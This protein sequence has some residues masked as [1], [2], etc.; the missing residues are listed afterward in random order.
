MVSAEIGQ[1]PRAEAEE[2][3]FVLRT[4]DF[5]FHRKRIK[6]ELARSVFASGNLDAGTAML[7]RHLQSIPLD[8]V[9]RIL[10]L[11]CGNG[12]LGVVLRALDP[13]RHL[14][15]VD[16][17]ALACRYTRRNLAGNG[18]GSGSGLSDDRILGSLGY[19]DI[20]EDRFDLI[21]S[22][23]PGKAG[24]E[25]IANLIG[26]AASVADDGAIVGLVVV[27]P[28]AHLVS[29][30]VEE[31]G[32]EVL[33]AKGNNTHH[34]ILA[35]VT[36]PSPSSLQP[37][38]A[39]ATGTYDRKKAEFSDRSMRWTVRTVTGLPEFDSLSYPS[40]MLRNALQGVEAGP[41]V[42]VNAG[43]GHRAVIAGRSG[44]PPATLI[45][46]DLLSL[47][48]AS[49]SLVDN[50]FASPNLVHDITV[51]AGLGQGSTLVIMHGDDKVHA[52]YFYDQVV[53]T[54]DHLGHTAGSKH[55]DLVLTGRASL[56][57]RLESD[58]LRTRRGH[59]A[60]KMSQ[61]GFRAVRYRLTAR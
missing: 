28:L 60:Y 20:G 51:S 21:V 44:Y 29:K 59:V 56:L 5:A 22:N 14:T 48:A 15:A 45:A 47:Q 19:D 4:I 23:L 57:G 58:L 49:R 42:V 35:R 30:L 17:D 25:V 38:G 54:L 12:S 27:D 10:D 39:F 43:Q 61:R 37:V 52:P 9:K 16:R 7:L 1:W 41:S 26:G 34:V 33:L 11:G 8:H 32:Y 50:G 36:E 40:R 6:L 53:R 24:E 3:L 13:G 18:L 31:A 2:D 46:R 55:R